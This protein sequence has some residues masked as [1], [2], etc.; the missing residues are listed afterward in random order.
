MK[1]HV[2]CLF[3]MQHG[4]T[5]T[6]PRER[7]GIAMEVNFLKS[8]QCYRGVAKDGEQRVAN[9]FQASEVQHTNPFEF[10]DQ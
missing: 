1:S 3:E 5:G 10:I 6:T 8:R 9:Q 2:F 4:G 7:K